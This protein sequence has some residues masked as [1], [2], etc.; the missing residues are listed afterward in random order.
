MH[1]QAGINPGNN[2]GAAGLAEFEGA[3]GIVG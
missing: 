3:L 1:R 2:G